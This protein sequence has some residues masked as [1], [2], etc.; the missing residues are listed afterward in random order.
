MNTDD[1]IL[2][3]V[4]ENDNFIKY[5]NRRTCHLG[6]GVH[7]RAFV[8]LLENSKG[9]VL[10]Q[11]RKHKLWD[12]F[13]DTTA[14][15]HPLHLKTGDESYETAGN[16]ALK[17]EMGIPQIKLKKIGGFNYFVPHGDNCEN[18]Y[19]AILTGVYNGEVTPNPDAVYTY[20]WVSKKEFVQKCLSNDSSYAPWAILTGDFLHNQTQ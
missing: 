19:C 9:D 13:W 20:K 3:V 14:I 12:N 6:N 2:F 1:Q 17:T 16:R 15:S 7:H 5:E 18:E 11:K 10:L 8:V 4:D